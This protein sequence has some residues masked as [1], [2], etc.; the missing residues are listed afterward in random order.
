MLLPDPAGPHRTSNVLRGIVMM[1][2][3]FMHYALLPLLCI[4]PFDIIAVHIYIILMHQGILG[5]ARSIS[6][7]KLFYNVQFMFSYTVGVAF[8]GG[9]VGG[10]VVRKKGQHASYFQ[11]IRERISIHQ[12]LDRGGQGVS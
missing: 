12:L 2:G 1:C 6:S 5:K 3:I 9:K 8:G 7:N 11:I 4:L 10:S